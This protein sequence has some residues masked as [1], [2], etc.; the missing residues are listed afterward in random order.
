MPT[1]RSFLLAHCLIFFYGRFGLLGPLIALKLGLVRLN[2]FANLLVAWYRYC[3]AAIHGNDN[4]IPF[5]LQSEGSAPV[6][7]EGSQAHSVL[8][9]IFVH[10]PRRLPCLTVIPWTGVN[11]LH[12]VLVENH[13][14]GTVFVHLGLG[15]GQ[16][17]LLFGN[18][19]DILETLLRRFG[20]QKIRVS[21]NFVCVNAHFICF[22]WTIPVSALK[23]WVKNVFF[24]H[25][26]IV[27]KFEN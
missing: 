13:L 25:I 18:D 8:A 15:Q 23:D 1:L 10:E 16:G 7:L 21:D 26:Q 5:L 17:T 11:R 12:E 20:T 6:H 9:M 24:I 27:I 22:S 14:D 4:L 2:D 3:L 19:F